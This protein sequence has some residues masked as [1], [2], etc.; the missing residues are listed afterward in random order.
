MGLFVKWLLLGLLCLIIFV[1]FCRQLTGIQEKHTCII[2]MFPHL[3]VVHLRFV[4]P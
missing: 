2:V 1:F 4:S 3:E